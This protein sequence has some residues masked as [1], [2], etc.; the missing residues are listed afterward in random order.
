MATRSTEAWWV[1]QW[2]P[3]CKRQSPTKVRIGG[4]NFTTDVRMVPAWEGFAKVIARHG[5]VVHPP[6]PEGD[7]GMYNCR[8]IG[9]D[10]NKPWST[11]SWGGAIDINWNTNPDGSRLTTDM[12]LALRSDLHALVTGSG[13]PVFRW[14]GDWDR[15]PRTDHSYYDAMHWEIV[16][17]PA[18]LATGIVDSHTT[19]TTAS[20]KQE[21]DE[22]AGLIKGD[23]KPEWWFTDG[24]KKRY[25]ATWSEAKKHAADLGLRCKANTQPFEWPQ[26]YVDAIP[27]QVDDSDKIANAVAAKL[28]GAGTGLTEAQVKSATTA[29]VRELLGGLDN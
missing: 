27:V 5:Y 18:E 6:Y 3:P 8:H 7:S 12:P 14:G 28:S 2:G 15:D 24:L 25:C 1:E 21:D 10:E 17:T 19:T 4:H 26:T 29:A 20:D 16:A 13:Q 9:N 11:H 22:V 23:A